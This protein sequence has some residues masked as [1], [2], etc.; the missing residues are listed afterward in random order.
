MPIRSCFAGRFAVSLGCLVCLVLVAKADPALH[1]RIEKMIHGPNYQQAR[2]GILVVDAATGRTIYE[3]DADRL[4]LP[5]STTKLYSCSAALAALGPDYR[6]QTPVYRRGSV[7]GEKLQGDLILVAQGDLTMG[8]RDDHGQLAF[9]DN[10]HI[11]AEF[12]TAT[13]LTHTDPLAGLNELARQVAASGIHEVQG[14]VLIDDRLFATS[15]GTGSG[16]D[17]LT[18]I[19]INDNVVDLIVTPGAK[20]G[21]PAKVRIRPETTYVQLDAQVKT[22]AQNEKS[23]IRLHVR[24]AGHVILRGQIAARSKPRIGI[25]A[26]DSPADFARTLFIEALRRQSVTVQA[27]PIDAPHAELPEKDSYHHLAR[28]A[29]LTSLPLSEV[30][31]VTLKV[32]HNLYASTLPLL[33]AVHEHERTLAAGLRWQ[34]HFLA[35]LGVDVATISFAGGAGGANADSVTPRATVQLLRA[36][37]KRPEYRDLLAGLPVLGIDGTLADVVPPNSTARG[38][39]QAKT[40]TLV[41]DDLMNGRELL[42]SKA[43]AGVMTTASGRKLVLAVFL[44]D[45]PLP[46]GVKTAR[47]GKAL[48]HLCEILYDGVK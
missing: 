34:R 2:W 7:K 33:V 27:S 28:V 47:E 16:P 10:D 22:V 26:V 43:L 3:H 38:K 37:S 35:G 42:R 13:G 18:P 30:I 12:G 48:G 5:A 17:Q 20:V 8:G 31:K 9:C 45:V 29:Q 24:T 11:Y 19:V 36:F 1:N 40:G 25:Y 39:V 15:H 21:Q 41:W 44:N 23:P 4:F 46:P 14:D 32:S 6:F